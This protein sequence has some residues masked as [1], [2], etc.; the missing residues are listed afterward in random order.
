MLDEGWEKVAERIHTYLSDS[1]IHLEKKKTKHS[2]PK[3]RIVRNKSL[4][5]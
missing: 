4:Q 3:K 2:F 5:N 1:K